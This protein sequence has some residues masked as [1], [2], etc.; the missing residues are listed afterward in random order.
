MGSWYDERLEAQ[1]RAYDRSQA[2]L[3][4]ARFALLFALA[5]VFWMSGW[6]RSLAE[7]LR[8][9]LT[10]PYSWAL[11]HAAFVALAVFGYE[12]VLF[13]LSVL[14][15]YS[16]E[17][18]HGRMEVEF[19]VWLRGYLVTLLLEIGLVTVGFAGL[20]GL[21]RLFP[22]F[23]WLLAAG[24]YAALVGGL[25]EWGPSRLLPKVR[26]PVPSNDPLLEAE[27]RRVGQVAGVEIEGAAWWDFE[28]QEDL[29]AVRLAGSGCRRRAIYSEWAWRTLGRPEQVFVAARHMAWLR[30]RAMLAVQLLQAGLAAMV[31][32]GAAALADTVARARGLSGATAP[33]AFPFL[34]VALFGGAAVAGVVAHAVVRRMELRADRFALRHAGG[35]EVL[36][37][38]LRQDFLHEPFAVDAPAWQVWLLRRQPTALRRLAQAESLASGPSAED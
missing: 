28:H 16:L 17:R 14:A 9:G 13:P 15:D 27:L 31:F 21:M 36:R 37:S 18:A 35:G 23:W 20:Y 2:L 34:V 25:G 19:G 8:R 6:S 29:E 11:V 1:A 12:A 24:A 5:A 26:P 3:F 38:C 22:S 10:F 33:E 30:S 7:G 32:L 4:L